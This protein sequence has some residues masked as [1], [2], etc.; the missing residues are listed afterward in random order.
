[1]TDLALCA[2]PVDVL[3]RGSPTVLVNGLPAVRILVDTTAHGGVVIFGCFTVWIGDSGIGSSAVSTGL[4][5]EVDKIAVLSP[6]LQ[7]NIA[8]LK[9]DG[10]TIEYGD[11]GKGSFTDRPG[12]RILIDSNEKGNPAKAAQTVA[13]ESG[14]ARYTPDPYVPPDGLTRDQYVQRN[15]DRSLKD[16]GE[17]TLT[18]AQ[19]RREIMQNRRPDIGIAGAQAAKYDQIAQ[20]YPTAS[21]REQAR[22]E[23]GQVFASGEHPSTDPTKTYQ[24][25]YA[26]PFED[27]WDKN[28]ATT[29]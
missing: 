2:G 11:A 12:K 6:T 19:V 16:E 10:W 23:I 17:A 13:H 1:M 29:P 26:K 28:V 24:Q 22:N 14:H 4:G 3:V 5:P 27:H 25:Y 18:N 21:Q 7:A 20:K 9:A 8:A 15:V